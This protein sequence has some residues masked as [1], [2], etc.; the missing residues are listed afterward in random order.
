MF[1]PHVHGGALVAATPRH[2]ERAGAQG[3]AAF[4]AAGI[5]LSRLAGLVRQSVF[6][7][8]LGTSDA[9]DAYNAAFKIPTSS[10]TSSARECSAPPSS[11]STLPCA[12]R[13]RG[14]G[15]QGCGRGRRAAHPVTTAFTVAGVAATP[16]SSTHRAR[17]LGRQ[18]RAHH[19][20]RP[21]LLPRHALLVL[22]AFCL[23]SSTATT[24]SSSATSRRWS[25][26]PHRSPPSSSEDGLRLGPFDLA[27]VTAWARCRS[28]P[29]VAVQ[30]P[31]CSPAWR[32]APALA[33][34]QNQHVRDVVRSFFPSSRDA[35]SSS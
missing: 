31:G 10:R 7:H 22:S 8:Y 2:G 28:A 12:R 5:L 20:A 23:G 3:G 27:V 14:R 19:P 25:G 34:P 16:S 30:L 35:E 33:R 17:V 9:A 4:V 29:P 32:A 21:H 11:R 15:A 24:G 26:A 18:A 6:G 13:R 1:R